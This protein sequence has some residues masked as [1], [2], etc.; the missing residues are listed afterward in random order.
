MF[1][2]EASFNLV[3]FI[4]RNQR[5]FFHPSFSGLQILKWHVCYLPY[6]ISLKLRNKHLPCIPTDYSISQVTT[7][8]PVSGLIVSHGATE[9][10]V[11]LSVKTK[12]VFTGN[13]SSVRPFG[14]ASVTA[15]GV[16]NLSALRL[17]EPYCCTTPC[18]M[19]LGSTSRHQR[20]SWCQ[21]FYFV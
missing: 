9:T 21:R 2:T 16:K 17:R 1:L 11:H 14:T 5:Q 20:M 10:L 8:P 19:P 18:C 12:V 6:I 15:V 3:L 7:K 4:T 13:S